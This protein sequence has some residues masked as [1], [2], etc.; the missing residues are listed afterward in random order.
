M[1]CVHNVQENVGLGSSIELKHH[2]LLCRNEG[3]N[4]IAMKLNKHPASL[5]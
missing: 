3:Q 2:M 1:N 5:S 4:G